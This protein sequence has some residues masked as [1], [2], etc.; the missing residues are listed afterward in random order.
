MRLPSRRSW[1]TAAITGL[2]LGIV[3][4]A[5]ATA[6]LFVV[7]DRSSGPPGT[8]IS[9]QTAGLGAF[10]GPLDPLRTFLIRAAEAED[11]TEPM[12]PRLVEVGRLIVDA[13]GNGR[14][15]F[16]VPDVAPGAYVVMAHCPSCAPTSAG[17]TMAPLADFR[18]T[19]LPTTDTAPNRTE[20]A[21]NLILIAGGV[22]AGVISLAA[23][24]R[25]LAA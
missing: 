20:R 21:P 11:I 7:L 19:A 2:I 3:Q 15:T 13:S 22:L 8:R 16:V 12:D 23:L 5:I 9:G 14:L 18:V 10:L 1:I 4:V 25:R 6:S 17:R 24:R